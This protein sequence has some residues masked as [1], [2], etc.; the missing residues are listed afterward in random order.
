MDIGIQCLRDVLLNCS[1]HLVDPRAH[2]VMMNYGETARAA[3]DEAMLLSDEGGVPSSS[4]MMSHS[5]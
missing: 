1:N 2:H 5:D 4:P 3:K